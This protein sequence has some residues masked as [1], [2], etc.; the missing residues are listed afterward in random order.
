MTTFEKLKQLLFESFYAGFQSGY[1]GDI[2]VVSAY[3]KWWE[4]VMGV[5]RTDI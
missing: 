5:V 3:E 1:M 4:S 2:G